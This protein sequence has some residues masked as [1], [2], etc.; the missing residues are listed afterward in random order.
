MICHTCQLAAANRGIS[1]L[2]IRPAGSVLLPKTSSLQ[3][4]VRQL[5]LYFRLTLHFPS[6]WKQTTFDLLALGSLLSFSGLLHAK[7]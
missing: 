4:P 7:V 5:I 3:S 2:P 6:C 1:T